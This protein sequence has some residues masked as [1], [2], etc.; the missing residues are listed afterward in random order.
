[1]RARSCSLVGLIAL[2][3]TV[4]A[5]ACED[6]PTGVALPSSSVTQPLTTQPIAQAS[7][8][9]VVGDTLDFGQL[10]LGSADHGAACISSDAS[11]AVAI[12]GSALVEVL[13]AGDVQIDCDVPTTSLDSAV[14]PVGDGAMTHYVI[15]LHA[16][17]QE[18]P[19]PID[20]P[21]SASVVT[22]R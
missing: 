17:A 5:A 3:A 14:L 19:M 1:M 20:V 22:T 13:G 2:S 21:D 16:A 18:P 9:G 15:R 12:D 6:S 11:I 7:L 10:V 8:T 4:L